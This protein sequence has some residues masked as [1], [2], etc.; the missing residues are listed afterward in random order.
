[1]ETTQGRMIGQDFFDLRSRIGTALFSLAKIAPEAGT[2]AEQ[3]AMIENLVNTLKDP[4]VFV[5]VG[6]V[7]VGKSTFLNALFSA[8]I[9]KTGVIPTTDKILFFKHGPQLKRVPITRTLEE[10]F[11]PVDFL[12]DFHIVDT[13]GTNSIENEHQEI[14][15]RFVPMADL[16]LFVFSA[17]N[18]WG[19]SAWQFL[20]KV[21]RRWMRHVVFVLQQCDL[22]TDDEIAAIL[23]YMR[24]LCRQRFEREFPIFPVSA[25]KAYLARSGGLD[26]DRLM[27]ESGFP[28]L[29]SHISRTIGGSGQRLGKL[30][31]ALHSAGGVLAAA[32]KRSGTK[33][34]AREE[35]ARA[36]R[37]L[38]YEL[39]QS[40]DRT[41]TKLSSAIEATENDF[42][43]ECAV[44]LTRVG[45]EFTTAAALRSVPGEK[46][47][48]TGMESG[49]L[50]RLRSGSIDRW[51]GAAVIVEDDVCSA[52]S[53]LSERMS[54]DLKVQMR[55]ELR[56][57]PDFWQG[58]RFRFV[59]HVEELLQASVHQLGIERALEP[60]LVKTR[61]T[62]AIF[63][64]A[65]LVTLIGA[66][67]LGVLQYWMLAGAVLVG[68][69]VFSAMTWAVCS[70]ALA[71][72]RLATVERLAAARPELRTRL[73]S[74]LHGEVRNLYDSF[75]QFLLPTREKL[76]E[77][78]ARQTALQTQL[79]A[80][81]QAFHGLDRELSDMVTVT[82][83]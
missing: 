57:D 35:K 4:F 75:T 22:R 37:Q 27:A 48:V 5:V 6:E 49:L 28:G 71:G 82:D 83:R 79:H 16:V 73:A 14:T 19:A 18:P 44:I 81:E 68:G 8:D 33:I 52:A 43:R 40:E 36:L 9:T 63:V 24:Q 47:S 2:D 46:R 34:A 15:E 53:R 25:K 72:A 39:M 21:H 7:N 42:E 3:A 50:E 29:E 62:A 67:V 77:Q 66:T 10:V 58:Q 61:K 76:A 31:N 80:M 32:S 38:E 1:M 51:T 41:T 70:R 64:L 74:H 65:A 59:S 11:L 55:D 30:S 17:M 45:E 20:E 56:P 23:D 54:E 69:V 13:P 78:E 12:R 60:V 26:H